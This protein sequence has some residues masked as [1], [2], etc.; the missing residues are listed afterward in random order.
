[1]D[2]ASA[3]LHEARLKLLQD[4]AS[5]TVRLHVCTSPRNFLG[6]LVLYLDGIVG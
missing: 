1:M 5:S 4:A 3:G 2:A 6:I